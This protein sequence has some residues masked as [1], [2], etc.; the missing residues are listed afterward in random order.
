MRRQLLA[1]LS[2]L[3]LA[4]SAAPGTPQVVKGKDSSATKTEAQQ[5]QNQAD[6]AVL[7]GLSKPSDA[8]QKKRKAGGEQQALDIDDKRKRTAAEVLTPQGDQIKKERKGD[9]E[10]AASRNAKQDKWRKV[11]SEN[12]A[13]K[14]Q[15]TIML[16][17]AQTV[18][19]GM[20]KASKATG[21]TNSVRT[22]TLKKSKKGATDSSAVQ[23][24]RKHIDKA[25]PK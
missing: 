25:S 19:T 7:I 4:G 18:G 16:T 9:A 2:A 11:S 1:L 3:G 22:E 5:K 12:A 21:E 17:N 15:Q 24:E 14:R 6:K 23:S 13:T 8:K 20:T 10:S